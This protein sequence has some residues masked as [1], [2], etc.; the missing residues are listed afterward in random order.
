MRI[1]GRVGV[2]VAIWLMGVPAALYAQA[3]IAGVVRDQSG[4]ALPGVTVEATSPVLIEKVRTVV[5]GGTGQYQVVDL[6]PGTYAIAFTL[7][8][9]STVRREGIELVGSFAATVDV[10]LTLGALEETITVTGETPVVDVRNVTRQRVMGSDVLDVIPSG[11]THLNVAELI[12]GITT[13]NADVGGTSTIG[14]VSSMSLH[15]SRGGDLRVELDGLSIANAELA[16]QASNFI[17]NAGST[18][19]IA[20]DYAANSAEHRTGG[21]RINIIPRE[22]GNVFSGSFFGTAVNSAFQGSNYTQELEDAGLGTPNSIRKNYDINPAVGGPI[23]RDRL[24]FYAAA[25]WHGHQ[26]NQAGLYYNLN[27]GNPDEW[28]YVPDTSRP[29]YNDSWQ[30]SANLRLTWQAARKHKIAVF[31][32]DQNRCQCPNV[33][34]NRS[35]EAAMHIEYPVNRLG[36]VSWTSPVTNRLLLEARVQ[37]RLERY[38]YNAPPEGD[39]LIPVMEQSTGLLYRGGG[40][41]TIS[42]PSTS[43]YASVK[44]NLTSFLV[45]MSYVTGAHALKI[46]VTDTLGSRT[47]DVSDNIHSLSYRFNNGIPNQLRMGATPFQRVE[48]QRA[49]LGIFAQDKWTA[50]DLTLNL[51]VRFDYYANYFPEQYLGPARFLPTRDLT[52]PETPWASW[53]D[54]TPRLGASYDLFGTGR[55]AVKASLNKYMIAFGLQGL[56]GDAGNPVNRLANFVTR[57]WNDA[58]RNVVPDCDLLNPLANGEC[59]AM[60]NL[61]FGQPAPST[62]YDPE[63]LTANR[64]YNW[65]FSTGIQHE[66]MPRMAVDV[67]YFRRWYGNFIATD[68]QAVT[69]A[70]YDPFSITAPSDPRLPGGGGHVIGGLYNL[71]PTKVGQVDNYLTLASNYGRQIERWNGVDVT[72]N[73]RLQRGVL[74]QGGLSTGRTTTDNCAVLAQLPEMSPTGQPYCH[75]E[76]AFLTQIKFLGSYLLPKLDVQLSAAF[77]SIPGPQILANYNAPNAQVAPSLGRNLSANAANVTVNLVEPGTMYGERMNRLDV[78]LAKVFRVARSRTALNFDLYNALNTSAVVLQNNNFAVWQRPQEIVLARFAKIS[79]QFDF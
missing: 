27:A 52:L 45:S 6:R 37:N 36:S 44:A 50:G 26:T 14:I 76:T 54:V 75:V 2:I 64:G 66:V 21:V 5:T 48:R 39:Q 58:N 49:D 25:R 16:G 15:G 38:S 62:S 60:S 28:L 20:I 72:A 30:R 23:V 59:G 19:E 61:S 43:P 22:G 46:G 69:A 65:E 47:S 10:V 8:G 40:Y 79:V 17:P 41:G 1:V 7:P 51:G 67:S 33:F 71:N 31:Y 42:Q 73:A 18:Q 57:N 74:L 34:A 13:S 53:K 9:F 77:Q 24:W 78:R 4:A 70:D 11:R 56:F 3:S 35:P 32:D 12:P 55:T 63:I 68:N 29:A